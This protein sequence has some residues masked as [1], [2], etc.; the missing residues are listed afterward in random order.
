MTAHLE[1]LLG[2]GIRRRTRTMVLLAAYHGMRVSEIAAMRGEYVDQLGG[3]IRIIGKGGKDVWLPIHPDIAVEAK[4][5]PVR[6]LWFPSYISSGHPISSKS[7]SDTIGRAMRRCGIPGTPHSLRHW[8]GT[9]LR[10]AGADP[11]VMKELMR[12]DSMATT[13]L[14]T[15]IDD[16]D[17]RE[18]LERLPRVA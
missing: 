1:A 18:A 6:G 17:Q 11:F 8:H 4:R 5:Y 2:C 13:A 10:R 15:A 14:Y 7:V 9:E 16:D 12:H 3:R